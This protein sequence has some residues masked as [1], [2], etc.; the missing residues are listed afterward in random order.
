MS[1]NRHFVQESDGG[2]GQYWCCGVPDRGC[3]VR[4][5]IIIIVI[6]TPTE[7]TLSSS[8]S[9]LR[10]QQQQHINDGYHNNN[11]HELN[12]IPSFKRYCMDLQ[13]YVFHLFPHL[14]FW[15]QS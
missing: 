1:T 7:T 14:V 6:M 10:Q 4:W 12:S 2:N 13:L 5:E 15:L 9:S 11:N 8:P 3:T